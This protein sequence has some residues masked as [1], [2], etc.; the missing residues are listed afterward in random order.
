MSVHKVDNIAVAFTFLGKKGVD[1]SFM[2]PQDVFDNG[3]DKG[4]ILSLFIGIL[5]K[6]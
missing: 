1:T 4:K 2:N 6:F 5:K 3:I